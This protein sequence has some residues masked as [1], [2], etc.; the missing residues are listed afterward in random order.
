MYAFS[1]DIVA[2]C[3]AIIAGVFMV[4]DLIGGGGG[5]GSK[6][7]NKTAPKGASKA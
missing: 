1:F 6:G 2:V 5:G 4:M 3:M 7:S